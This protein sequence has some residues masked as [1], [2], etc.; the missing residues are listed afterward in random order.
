MEE[1]R[2]KVSC[3]TLLLFNLVWEVRPP[4][5][6]QRGITE[7]KQ[8]FTAGMSALQ[9]NFKGRK[10]LYSPK[11]KRGEQWCIC[12]SFDPCFTKTVKSTAWQWQQ[13]FYPGSS[14]EVNYLHGSLSSTCFLLISGA[15]DPALLFNGLGVP[16]SGYPCFCTV[17]VC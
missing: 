12:T 16:Q 11:G 13:Y 3:V 2:R 17:V 15:S 5:R 1:P 14:E 4:V 10:Q 9:L 7:T 8:Q 6:R